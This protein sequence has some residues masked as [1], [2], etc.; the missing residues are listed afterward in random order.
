MSAEGNKRTVQSIFEAFGRGDVP[1][2][3]AHL[4]ED[5]TWKAPGPDVIPY[6]GDRSGHA[7]ATE[8]FVQ[9]GTNVD[10]EHFEPGTFVAEGDRV[11]V[12]GRERGRVKGTG[13]TFDNEWALVFTFGSDSKVIGFQCYENTAAIAEAFS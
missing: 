6:F 2:V 10:F 5:V 12:L 11:V 1:G 7:G 13:K 9:L 4:S 8:F 3:L